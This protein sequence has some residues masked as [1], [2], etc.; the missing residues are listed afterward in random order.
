MTKDENRLNKPK[1]HIS[2][3]EVSNKKEIDDRSGFEFQSPPQEKGGTFFRSFVRNFSSEI[4]S[5]TTTPPPV[6]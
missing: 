3:A 6:I 2:T 5:S 1:K 4:R